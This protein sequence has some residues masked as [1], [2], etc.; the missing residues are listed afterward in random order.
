MNIEYCFM[1]EL[2]YLISE[3]CEY[4]SYFKPYICVMNIFDVNFIKLAKVTFDNIIIML[5]IIV[6]INDDRIEKE[7]YKR[8]N[9]IYDDVFVQ[10]CT[11]ICVFTLKNHMTYE[12]FKT[13][14]DIKVLKYLISRD[15]DIDVYNDDGETMVMF[16]CYNHDVYMLKFL[17]ENGA[18]IDCEDND[19][20]TVYCR[21]CYRYDFEYW[22]D[23]NMCLYDV[24]TYLQ[25]FE[26]ILKYDANIY[27]YDRF[28]YSSV[29]YRACEYNDVEL[30]KILVSSGRYDK[31][32]LEYAY[33]CADCLGY[34]DICEYI[35][36]NSK[37]NLDIKY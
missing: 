16:A 15:V 21:I 13:T 14:K 32:Y 1:P 30:V 23:S 11:N 25:M 22:D 3:Y 18:D 19:G 37:H 28:P 17:L 34:H 29:L 7:F 6:D 27:K 20:N 4:D 9:S 10:Y 24:D 31:E 2:I 12:Q 36:D 35:T 8:Y 33:R 5:E 26:I